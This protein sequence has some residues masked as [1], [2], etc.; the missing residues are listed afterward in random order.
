MFAGQTKKY[1]SGLS[2]LIAHPLHSCFLLPSTQGTF[3]HQLVSVSQEQSL[4][5]GLRTI[6]PLHMGVSGASGFPNACW[7]FMTFI[8]VREGPQRTLLYNSTELNMSIVQ[9]SSGGWLLTGNLSQ[10]QL[11]PLSQI[12]PG[13]KPASSILCKSCI[14]RGNGAAITLIL[15][16]PTVTSTSRFP[17]L[18]EA[19]H[20]R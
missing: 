1:W 11:C 9:L 16:C 14:T 12:W 7:T 4:P 15:F 2:F 6:I 8:S 5:E 19:T 20:I 10:R 17:E 18:S 13:N 3:S